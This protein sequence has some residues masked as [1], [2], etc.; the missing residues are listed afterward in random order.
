MSDISFPNLVLNQNPILLVYI[1]PTYP[2]VHRPL[3]SHFQAFLDGPLFS[4]GDQ[5]LGVALVL[6]GSYLLDLVLGA[7]FRAKTEAKSGSRSNSDTDSDLVSSVFSAVDSSNS[8]FDF[9]ISVG[10]GFRGSFRVGA[11]GTGL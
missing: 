5:G 9:S 3:P 8:D 2:I 11:E 1:P 4:T 6:G 7:F 10:G